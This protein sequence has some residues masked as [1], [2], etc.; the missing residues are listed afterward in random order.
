M[1]EK[2]KLPPRAG[3]ESA[4]KRRVS[5]AATAT[6]RSGTPKSQKKKTPTP[7][8]PSQPPEPVETPLPTKLKDNEALPVT[9]AH[10]PSTLSDKEYQSIADSSVLLA[11]LERSKKKWLSEG[12][13]VRYYTKPKKTR[14]EQ[15]EKNNPSK[16]SMLKVGP[17]DITIGP[18]RFDAMIFTV[19]DPTAP[20]QIQYAPPQ[21]PMVHYGHPNSFQQYQP[22]QS[23]QQRRP[24]Y[25]PT[26]TG[27]PAQGYPGNQQPLHQH[28]GPQQTPPQ[29]AQRP[30]AQNGQ[31]GQPA[32]P[33]PDP[34]IQML[35]T[36]AAADPEL[37]ALMRV[38][39]SSQATQEQLRAFQAHIDE[40]NAIIKA[41]EQREQ[42]QQQQNSAGTPAQ[43]QATTQP[44]SPASQNKPTPAPPSSQQKPVQEQAPKPQTA[45]QAQ[46]PSQGPQQPPASESKPATPAPTTATPKSVAEGTPQSGT[47]SQS[48]TSQTGVPSAAPQGGSGAPPAIKQE[49]A[50]TG[51]NNPQATPANSTNPT[52]STPAVVNPAPPSNT[53]AVTTPQQPSPAVPSPR[54]ALTQPQPPRP[55]T[56]LP[57]WQQTPYGGGQTPIQSRPPPYGS[58]TPYYRPPAPVPQPPTRIGY[59]AVVF[60]FTSPLTPYGSSTSGHAGS[61]DRYLFPEYSILEWRPDDNSIVASFLVTRKVDP[62]TPFPLETA[63]DAPAAKG[64]G[65]GAS[66]SKK[67]K[68][69]KDNEAPATPGAGQTATADTPLKQEPSDKPDSKPDGDTPAT[70]SQATTKE[71]NLKEYWQPVTFRIHA[72][73]PKILE[74]LI[75]VVKPPEEVRKYMND[76]MDRAERA[77]DG[78]PAIRLPREEAREASESEGTP[79]SGTN[80]ATSRNRISRG[81]VKIADEE[82]EVENVA[83]EP[84]EEEELVDFYGAP[85]WLPPG[86]AL[87]LKPKPFYSMH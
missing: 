1:A 40:L 10:Q 2:R 78:F 67:K 64:K 58:P 17:C 69:D 18:H 85:A 80:R 26:P 82:S 86:S 28:R 9:R 81:N 43:S 77:P 21:R 5:E 39:A 74:P 59:K 53:A 12:I 42:Q 84:V 27:R 35:A 48:Q 3:R 68:A 62:N 71:A 37:K 52:A 44:S 25:P 7:R 34:V 49:P 23:N 31:P 83:Q 29:N 46:T 50:A 60:E 45:S 63:T 8:V 14:R 30:Q 87:E 32:K 33:S 36:R 57:P 38:V 41:R 65:K 6:P 4:A 24:P 79:A 73:S 15:I 76:I 55:G 16:D 61:G 22:Y 19:K 11:S 70:P 75:R 66:K 20:Q 51:S 56:S 72:A 13:L 47:Q 54:P